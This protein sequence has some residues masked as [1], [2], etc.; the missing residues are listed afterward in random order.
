MR[1]RR[2]IDSS[3]NLAVPGISSSLSSPGIS[4]FHD[5]TN[6]FHAILKEYPELTRQP[7]CTSPVKHSVV[8]H[9]G[10]NKGPPVFVR[11]RRLAPEKL[12]IARDEFSHMLDMD[13]I[14]PSSS[15]WAS[16]LHMMP[17]KQGDW[18]PCGDYRAL[19][20]VTIP[21][22]YLIPHVHDFMAFL[23]G[24]TVY[25]KFD[26]VRAHHQIPVAE[27][28]IPK[29]A[30]TTPFGLFEFL[31]MP[32]GLCNGA[33]SFQ[34]FI[35]AVARGLSFSFA[36]IDDILV[37]SS[38]YKDHLDHLRQLLSRL[39]D[40]GIIVNA[41]KSEFGVSSLEFLW[42]KISPEG[43]TPLPS[44]VQVISD[45]PRPT[46]NPVAN[47]LSRAAIAALSSSALPL[48]LETI[49][50]LQSCDDELLSL[51]DSD[52]TSLTLQDIT[53]PGIPCVICY[54]ISSGQPRPFL[55]LA[56]RRPIFDQLHGMAHP[57]IRASQ[58]LL[59]SRYVWP[60]M[61]SDIKRWVRSCIS[62]Q[63][64]KILRHTC[65]PSSRLPLPDSRFS[66][67]HPDLV[68]P[69]PPVQGFRYLLTVVDR[70]TRW[71]GATP[72]SD[73]TA[74]TVASAFLNS[75]VARFVV[76]A[77]MITDQGRQFESRL[78]AHLTR[79]FGLHR[80]RATAYHPQANGMVEPLNRDLKAA[81]KA[82]SPTPWV[83]ALPIVLLSLRATVRHDIECAP[84]E[85][86]YGMTLRLP[87]HEGPG[88]DIAQQ[89]SLIVELLP[90]LTQARRWPP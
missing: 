67:I 8:H 24:T 42:H 9:I 73:I 30:I 79:L 14:R 2:L 60:R 3:T 75:W 70:F 22:R 39:S 58:K 12:K 16:A 19:N 66:H 15:S 43:I 20:R 17:K 35:D 28:D 36:Y 5:E 65:T 74:S 62:C 10:T 23:H 47:A 87:D 76:P 82:V 13:I 61:R 25:S 4:F 40:H 41:L 85:L 78:F 52:P 50:D 84:A 27:E 49:A 53:F 29:T 32:F 54:D 45:Y 44:K 63:K 18:R 51:R 89:F 33:Q 88:M 31:C 69:L 90:Y 55:P 38:S 64:S 7:D 48:S 72:I 81:L 46:S 34:R 21:D 6:P 26:L 68:G 86:V 37:A 57:G 77:T 1:N 71:P 56:A 59:S 83:E 11:P 80:I